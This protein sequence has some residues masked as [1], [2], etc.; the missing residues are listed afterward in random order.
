V[1]IGCARAIAG[2]IRKYKQLWISAGCLCLQILPA[3]RPPS[4][5]LAGTASKARAQR[6]M[7]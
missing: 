2:R 5:G 4:A 3:I 7:D 1:W 6:R